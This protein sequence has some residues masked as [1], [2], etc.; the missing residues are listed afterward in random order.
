MWHCHA[1]AKF[2]KVR[3]LGMG[4][5]R[6][7]LILPAACTSFGFHPCLD[8]LWSMLDAPVA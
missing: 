1:L 6:L 4:L 2:F 7:Q 3:G 8:L 5:L